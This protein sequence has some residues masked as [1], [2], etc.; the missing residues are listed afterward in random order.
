M[1]IHGPDPVGKCDVHT[2]FFVLELPLTPPKGCGTH[3]DRQ[4]PGLKLLLPAHNMRVAVQ[5]N[6]W[7]KKHHTFLLH[8]KGSGAIRPHV[9]SRGANHQMHPREPAVGLRGGS[10]PMMLWV[11]QHRAEGF[12]I[13]RGLAIKGAPPLFRSLLSHCI[14]AFGPHQPFALGDRKQAPAE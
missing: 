2:L 10:P 9:P 8:D 11:A 4:S 1:H 12:H 14:L 6:L 7:D 5:K 3:V 13:T